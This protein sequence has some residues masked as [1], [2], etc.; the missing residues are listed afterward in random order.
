MGDTH[1]DTHTHTPHVTHT[2]AAS[3]IHTDSCFTHI[4]IRNTRNTDK[5]HRDMDT[6]RETL[7][8]L[9]AETQT[10][11]ETH[12]HVI[13]HTGMCLR[14]HTQ[15]TRTHSPGIQMLPQAPTA[16]ASPALQEAMSYEL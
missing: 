1:S 13:T 2:V 15:H 4:M 7:R 8:Y 6:E 11:S 14:V 9:Q 16:L 12:S 5:T 10:F 3:L